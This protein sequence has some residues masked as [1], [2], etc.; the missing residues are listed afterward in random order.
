MAQEHLT[1]TPTHASLSP[2]GRQGFSSNSM[3]DVVRACAY[4]AGNNEA[5]DGWAGCAVGG[6]VVGVVILGK[7]RP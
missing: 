1:M 2:D 4:P 3:S 5:R 6:D 7:C